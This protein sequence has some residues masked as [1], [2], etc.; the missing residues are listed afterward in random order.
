MF[1]DELGAPGSSPPPL[2]LVALH[3]ATDTQGL[4]AAA[5]TAKRALQ[6]QEQVS[7]KHLFKLSAA[8]AHLATAAEA[9]KAEQVGLQFICAS[10]HMLPTYNPLRFSP[11][12]V[13]LLNTCNA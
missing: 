2:S 8:A 10:L 11:G 5:E 1:A 13:A 4:V 3:E 7:R 12:L 6:G 9:C